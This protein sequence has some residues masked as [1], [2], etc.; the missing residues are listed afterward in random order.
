MNSS[1]FR[2][3]CETQAGLTLGIG[4]GESSDSTF[5]I[6]HMGHLNPPM[7]LG[8]LGTIEAALHNVGAPMGGS[9]VAAAAE[10]LGGHF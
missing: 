7:L 6:G 9:G 3:I 8:T 10:L 5:R 1:D 2:E 4:V